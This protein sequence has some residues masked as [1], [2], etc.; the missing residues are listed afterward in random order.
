M[1]DFTLYPFTVTN[2]TPHN[3]PRSKKRE[4]LRESTIAVGFD[5][6]DIGDTHEDPAKDRGNDVVIVMQVVEQGEHFLRG[7]EFSIPIWSHGWV[8]P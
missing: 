5:D 7:G 4:E 2:F 8:C 3:Q 6:V 1:F